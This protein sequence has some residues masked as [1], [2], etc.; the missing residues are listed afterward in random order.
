MT[1]VKVTSQ[2]PVYQNVST[3]DDYICRLAQNSSTIS[4][5]NEQEFQYVKFLY[6]IID[7]YAFSY[8]MLIGLAYQD[9]H[10]HWH[11]ST[12]FN[13]TGFLDIGYKRRLSE[14]KKGA[15][16]RFFI[17][18]PPTD[19]PRK[20]YTFDINCNAKLEEVFILCRYPLNRAF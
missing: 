6:E 8:P 2:R 18:S 3:L 1:A 11:D 13:Y 17:Y 15:C 19:D 10:F 7:H 4:I 16:R 9:E 14:L 20:F 12:P 5:R